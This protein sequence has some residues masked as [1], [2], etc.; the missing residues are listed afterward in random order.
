M[1]RGALKSSLLLVGTLGMAEGSAGELPRPASL[2]LRGPQ[3]LEGIVGVV[4][5]WADAWHRG[6]CEAM[7]ACLHP[8]LEKRILEVGA[9]PE[10][11]ARRVIRTFGVQAAFGK[12]VRE[13]RATDIRVLDVQGRGASVRAD[14][15]PWT[16]FLHLATHRSGWAIANVLWEWRT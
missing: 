12:S 14:L 7:A 15:G 10:E 5:R 9:G 3:D 6:D 2:A 16:A 8:D 13:R 1:P 11:A 4:Q